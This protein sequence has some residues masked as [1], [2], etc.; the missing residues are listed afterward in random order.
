MN[1]E[2]IKSMLS[3]ITFNTNFVQRFVAYLGIYGIL[4]IIEFF[5]GG[6]PATIGWYLLP[7][8]VYEV[9]IVVL[10]KLANRK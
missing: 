4:F 7:I 3:R 1:K 9:L 8:F 6:V 5:A 2:K 10:S